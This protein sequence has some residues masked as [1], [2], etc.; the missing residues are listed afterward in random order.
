MKMKWP[1]FAGRAALGLL[2][3]CAL[4]FAL[5]SLA[6]EPIFPEPPSPTTRQRQETLETFRLLERDI[7][8]HA[9][10][11]EVRDINGNTN[12][13]F[14]QPPANETVNA[15]AL[16]W[17]QDRDP[18]DV[19]L[20]RTR[21]LADDL[22]D[23]VAQEGVDKSAA[24]GALCDSLKQLED[25]VKAAPVADE[26]A[27]YILFERA[28]RLRRKIAFANPLLKDIDK[29]LFITRETPTADEL[30]WG[31]HM[32]DQYFGFHATL[33]G[34]TFGNGIWT[35]EDPFGDNPKL[36]ELVRPGTRIHCA[37]PQWNNRP[38]TR[39]GG[40]LAPDLS[41]DGQE[42]LF[43]WTPGDYRTRE[44]DEKTTFHIMKMKADGSNLTMLTWGGVNDLFPCWLPNG[45]V[46]FVS[47]RRGGFG[48]CHRREVPT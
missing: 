13:P 4:A 9:V 23:D 18:L 15:Q 32:C 25:E 17:P 37:N 28:M 27:R 26:D 30:T 39:E 20:R 38:I 46:A 33:K 47:E 7:R 14:F 29:L 21:A 31:T 5:P 40:F 2:A 8:F 22:K 1:L 44:W 3:V 12:V 11:R 16:I 48:R 6:A 35:L 36:V 41:W 43:C 24:F 42:I 34:S 10:P 19:L 45:R